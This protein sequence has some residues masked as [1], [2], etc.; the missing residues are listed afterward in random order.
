MR[1]SSST[2]GPQY[3]EAHPVGE[4]DE[5]GEVVE[6]ERGH[7]VD[8]GPGERATLVEQRGLGGGECRFHLARQR[9]WTTHLATFWRHFPSPREGGK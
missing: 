5:V 8:L 6:R 3:V 7:G 4:G 2:A 9:R 1:L